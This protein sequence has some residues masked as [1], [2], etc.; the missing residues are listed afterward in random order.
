MPL[1]R[2][3]GMKGGRAD[4][5][6]LG[7]IDGEVRRSSRYATSTSM[8][9]LR[10]DHVLLYDTALASW[11]GFLLL[12]AKMDVPRNARNNKRTLN[13]ERPLGLLRTRLCRYLGYGTPV[14]VPPGMRPAA[15]SVLMCSRL[16]AGALESPFTG[17]D[18][19]NWLFRLV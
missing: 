3:A 14:Y 18:G 16:F 7:P 1:V 2:I 11:S 6:R 5:A 17:T 13:P 15:S 10:F 4:R 12:D 8:I 19:G 9:H